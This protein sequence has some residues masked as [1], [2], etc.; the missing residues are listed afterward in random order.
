MPPFEGIFQNTDAVDTDTP[1]NDDIDAIFSD[2]ED[3]FRLYLCRIL[4]ALRKDLRNSDDKKYIFDK[5]FFKFLR[6][7]LKSLVENSRDDKRFV[8]QFIK[9]SKEFIKKKLKEYRKNVEK[10]NRK[11][12]IIREVFW[13]IIGN[14]RGIIDFSVALLAAKYTILSPKPTVSR[15]ST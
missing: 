4:I 3:S 7:D 2:K 10:E 8:W 11:L 6:K 12:S 1:K 9:E 5:N 13:D 15:Y 14:G